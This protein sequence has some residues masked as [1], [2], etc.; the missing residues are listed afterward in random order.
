MQSPAAAYPDK[1]GVRPCARQ[2]VDSQHQLHPGGSPIDQV[3]P[4][5]AHGPEGEAFDQGTGQRLLHRTESWA[6]S[7]LNRLPGI[8]LEGDPILTSTA[9]I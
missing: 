6:H 5:H 4:K 7:S 3:S 1:E 9:R 2:L 8:A